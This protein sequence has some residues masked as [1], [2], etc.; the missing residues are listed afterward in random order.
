MQNVKIR[1]G[2]A[3]GEVFNGIWRTLPDEAV[4]EMVALAR[5]DFQL[6]DLEHA[7]LSWA[8]IQRMIRINNALDRA[9]F[10]RL[11]DRSPIAAQRALDAGAHGLVY[12]GVNSLEEVISISENLW[13][14]PKGRRG[15]NPFVTAFGYGTQKSSDRCKPVFIP[16]VETRAGLLALDDIA[17][18]PEVDV[19]Y[20]GA[21]DLS[22][23]LGTPGDISS[24]IV[25]D[26][27]KD[28]IAVCRK[29]ACAVGLMVSTLE[30][31][32][33]WSQLGVQVFLRGVDAG[34][35][36]KALEI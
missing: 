14:A 27:L 23:H 19:V 16:I 34:I 15:F 13:F 18:R 3:C 6:F 20:L 22:F 30:D 24:P 33:K 8:D 35:I 21:Y 9:S 10:V 4:T 7:A 1:H 36:R 32:K 17:S 11:G 29:H 25:Q 26:A 31:I 28:A 12:P 2:L 5:Y